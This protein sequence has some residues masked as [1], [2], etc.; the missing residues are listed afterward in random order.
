MPTLERKALPAR[1]S[2]AGTTIHTG[3]AILFGIP[4]LGMGSFLILSGTRVI[5]LP[6]DSDAPLGLVGGMGLLFA[7]AGFLI[8]LH[9]I[10]GLFR[11][12][13]VRRRK[14]E[15]PHEPWYWDHPWNAEGESTGGFGEQVKGLFGLGL[16]ALFLAPFNW[17]GYTTRDGIWIAVV[18]LFDLIL[19]AS[20]GAFIY[21]FARWVQYGGSR[22]RF[23]AFPF[24]LGGPFEA[25]LEGAHRLRSFRSLAITLRCVE[26]TYERQGRSTNVVCYQI[27]EDREQW[28]AAT[29]P[30]GDAS[31]LRIVFSLPV[32][33]EL[34]TRLA[35]APPRYWELELAADTPGIDY[36]AT[37]LVPVYKPAR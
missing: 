26:E 2:R 8:V 33:K 6:G 11:A 16:F 1:A 24:F 23:A 36:K 31:D 3:C 10:R 30:A 25:Y 17:I 14:R 18:G 28:T 19:V 5:D 35:Q 32:E 7:F 21:Q 20:L 34:A 29:S 15:R 4:F 12:A 22:L 13:G 27:Y 9:G 37:F